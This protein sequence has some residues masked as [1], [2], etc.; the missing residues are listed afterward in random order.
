[1]TD[2]ILHFTL[3]PVQGFIAEARR[4]RDFWAGSFL[5]SLL[6]GHAMACVEAHGGRIDFPA[7]DGD[8]LY[9]AICASLPTDRRP[10]DKAGGGSHDTH[11]GSLPNRFRAVVT[12]CPDDIGDL[13]RTWVLAAWET[14]AG[15]VWDRFFA[16][17]AVLGAD[18]GLAPRRI[19]ERQVRHFWDVA[20]VLGDDP[21]DGSDGRWLDLRKNWRNHYRTAGPHADEGGDRCRL[22]GDLE[23]L[24]GYYRTPSREPQRRFWKA[25]A[26]AP[27]VGLDLSSDEPLSAIGAIKRLFPRLAAI[28]G[29]MAWKPGGT[30][31]DIRHWPSVSY[32][33][34]V[35]WL[36]RAA[37]LDSGKRGRHA[38]VARAC[39]HRDVFGETTTGL[40]GL[41][42]ERFFQ[43][44]G[45]L[46]HE[47][48]LGLAAKERL[49]ANSGKEIRAAVDALA[50]T[51]KDVA[52]AVGCASSTPA[53]TSRVYPSTFY[54]VLQMD[55]DRIGA[56][57]RRYPATVRAGLQSFTA[58]VRA[59]F[60][61]GD[62]AHLGVLIYAGGDDVL[63]LLPID[64][65]LDAALALRAAFHD[66]F[67]AAAAEAGE[68]ATA[69]EFTLSGAI[70]AAQ[71]K[72]P[73]RT[74]LRHAKHAL[75]AHAKD[76]NGRDSL[77]IAIL[78]PGGVAAEW[79][80]VFA[81]SDG[82]RPPAII[83]D[84]A[85]R[86]LGPETFGQGFFHAIRSNYERLLEV[87][88]QAVHDPRRRDEDNAL[89]GDLLVY[90]YRR[91]F[92]GLGDQKQAEIDLR[93]ADFVAVAIPHKRVEGA[94]TDPRR[95]DF[96]AGLV[97]RF[98][99]NERRLAHRN[100]P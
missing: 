53:G 56:L 14:I 41:P 57:L 30:S 64:T 68:G 87:D 42:D 46:F 50:K 8:L 10:K 82:V 80:S 16:Q 65:A 89:M 23:E 18:E 83:V 84:L 27:N 93:L 43:L 69:D 45:P 77:A 94:S 79:V 81:R 54:A 3:G 25:V 5:L 92:V 34:A 36:L 63:A 26:G 37:A 72:I 9:E 32:I 40:F 38:E 98:F 78:K 71:Y 61:P 11:V 74:V 86:G 33:A 12:A 58:K 35:P 95:F 29:V 96:D 67:E 76:E 13:C 91:Q 62:N 47:D 99:A 60:D 2:R 48:G 31:I 22:M 19:F 75:E 4:T 17:H 59:L 90:E 1:M 21:G 88:E 7:I 52:E 97:V 15:Q 28:D 70:V 24:S 49:G 39:L 100:N 44:D 51:L 6:S 20:F 55:G 73:L 66:A 85:A